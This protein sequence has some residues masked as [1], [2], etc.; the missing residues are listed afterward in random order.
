MKSIDQP[1]VKQETL[2]RIQ[3]LRPDFN[4][5]W[6]R[7]NAR[8]MM[9][10]LN[11]SFRCVMG[12]IRVSVD[13]DFRFRGFIKW[14]GLYLPTPWPHGVRTRPE[15][16]QEHG[17]TPPGDFDEDRQMLV[18]LIERFARWPRDFTFDPHPIFLE[19]TEWQ[20]MRWGWLH[21]DHHLRQFRV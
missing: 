10:H 4:P 3:R 5:R 15:I 17:G 12:E 16:D 6:G 9:S 1:K 21:T 11:D 18:G 13:P 8:Q 2:E 20:W 14:C 7:M 19:M